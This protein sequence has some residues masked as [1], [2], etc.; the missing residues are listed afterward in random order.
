MTFNYIEIWRIVQDSFLLA[1]KWK[2]WK[3]L[4]TG[5]IGSLL[6]VLKFGRDF[7][8][9]EIYES[10]IYSL[11]SLILL[12]SL[13]F[14][15]IFCKESL[16]YFHEVYQNSM[17][18]DAIIMLK[19]SFAATNNYRKTPGHQDEEFMKSMILL[20]NNLKDIYDKITHSKC[21]VSIKVPL[22]DEKVNEHTVLVNLIRDIKNKS[23][24]TETY[25]NTKHTLIGNT[26]FIN[27]FNKVIK[28][29]KEKYYVNNYVNKTENYD[30]T[31]KECYEKGVFPYNSEL[32]HPIVPILNNLKKLDCHG[33]ICIDSDKENAF[34]SKYSYAILEGVADGIY[35]LISERNSCKLIRDEQY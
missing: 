35:D 6:G 26:P 21:F 10:V 30:N 31:S 8:S 19:D 1:L 7:L 9:L 14:I 32:V 28:N 5:S 16:K 20:C 12:F 25:S 23:R 24:D 27:S 22:S 18:G 2:L 34:T 13:R 29:I 4:L 11:S 33:F 3:W 15:L 17:Y